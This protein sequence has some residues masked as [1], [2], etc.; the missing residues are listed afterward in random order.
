MKY[1]S[2]DLVTLLISAIRVEF[3]AADDCELNDRNAIVA[4]IARITI[5]TISSTRVNQKRVLF[6]LFLNRCRKGF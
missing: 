4:R 2:R 3:L 1:S 6:F 5:T